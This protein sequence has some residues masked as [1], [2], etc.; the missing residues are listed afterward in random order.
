MKSN[1]RRKVCKKDGLRHAVELI[2]KNDNF[3]ITTHVHSEGDALGS[4]L[5]FRALLAKLGKKCV[6]VNDDPVPLEYRFL[7][8]AAGI[9]L[10]AHARDVAF[11]CLVTLDCSD[12]ARAGRVCSLNTRGM[13][14]L[15]ID[16]HVSNQRFADVN[17]VEPSLSSCC[18]LIYILYKTMRVPFDRATALHLYTGIMTDTGSFRF[19]N[20]SAHTHCAVAELMRFGLDVNA[21]HRRIYESIPYG[22]IRFLSTIYPS[23]KRT[24]RGQVVWFEIGAEA[25]RRARLSCDLTERVLGF[26]RSIQG[27]KVVALFKEIG[28][29]RRVRVNLRS[30]GDVD[31]NAIASCFG[32]GGHRTASGATV[33][34]TLRSV[35]RMVLKEIRKRLH[36][37][38]ARVI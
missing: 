12:A 7:P 36:E 19:P 37:R 34:G 6:I 27:V 17:W 23:L 10:F 25:I 13:P 4:E 2:R 16:H 9:R 1:R 14:T 15:N 31:V 28:G 29:V 30:Q 38:G 5:A 26:G 35:S 11:S 8:G 22:D 21:I 20:T 24:A 18:E 33:Q 32:G 3:L